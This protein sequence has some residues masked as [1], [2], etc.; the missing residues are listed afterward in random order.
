MAKVLDKINLRILE[1]LNSNARITTV[2][3]GN[4]VGLSAPAVAERIRKMEL[5]GIIAGYKTLI[6]YDMLGMRVP[7]FVHFKAKSVS[8]AAMVRLFATIPEIKEWYTIT[9]DNCAMLKIIVD[10]TATLEKLLE[11]LGEFGETS[12]SI[13][14]SEGRNQKL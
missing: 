8:H 4:R 1:E 10:T 5:D 2:E 12:T 11:K 14:L 7:V 3:V 9:G 13:I 6:N